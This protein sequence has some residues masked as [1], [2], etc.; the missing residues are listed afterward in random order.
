MT[1]GKKASKTTL[2]KTKPTLVKPKA[3]KLAMPQMEPVKL[4]S[5]PVEHPNR[6]TVNESEETE[7]GVRVYCST[8]LSGTVISRDV[9]KT[10]DDAASFLYEI[11]SSGSYKGNETRV[12]NARIQIYDKADAHS[13]LLLTLVLDAYGKVC[14]RKRGH[15]LQDYGTWRSEHGSEF[16]QYLK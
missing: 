15:I 7:Q 14:V 11:V 8:I 4:D 13:T 12:D 3:T 9:F 2:R 5:T 16:Q 10:L 1:E 6:W